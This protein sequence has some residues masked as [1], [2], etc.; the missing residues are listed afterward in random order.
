T[1]VAIATEDAQLWSTVAD[2]IW[3]KQLIPAMA[4]GGVLDGGDWPEG[5]QYGPLSVAELALASRAMRGAG[6]EVPNVAKWLGAL[7]R[8]YIYGLAPND[9][10]FPGED[11]ESE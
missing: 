11:T 9:R 1:M 10:E 2:T 8:V 3:S 5:W 6:M 7:L 4:E